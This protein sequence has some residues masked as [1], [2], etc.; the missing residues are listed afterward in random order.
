M[1][2]SDINK[3]SE[4]HI[5][6]EAKREI[7]RDLMEGVERLR[8]KPA[9]YLPKNATE[10][11]VTVDGNV[12][13]PWANRVRMSRL[14]NMFREAVEDAS[15]RAFAKPAK[16]SANMPEKLVE[17]LLDVDGQGS[18][19]QVFGKEVAET[20][21]SE[22]NDF[23]LVDFP[24]RPPGEVLTEEQEA[25][26]RLA[27]FWRRYS[28]ANVIDWKFGTR[29][30]EVRL[31]WVKLREWTDGKLQV[32]K[33]IAGAEGAEDES[34][35][36]RFEVW[37]P[38][39]EGEYSGEWV[40]ERA[41]SMNPQVDIPLVEFPSDLAAPFCARPPYLD[42]AHLTIA[43]YRKLSDL[44]NAQHAVGYPLL[45]WAGAPQPQLDNNG[46][47]VPLSS[48][49]L[50]LS[51]DPAAHAEFIE[52]QGHAWASLRVEL[53]RMEAEGKAM[54]AAPMSQ[55]VTVQL[56][57]TD[58][59][60][61]AAGRTTKLQSWVLG[62][63]DSFSMCLCYTAVFLGIVKPDA[64]KGWGAIEL[65]GQFLP[66]GSKVEAAR[67]AHERNI[68]GKLSDESTHEAM[69]RAEVLPE[70]LDFKAERARI[71][72]EGLTEPTDEDRNAPDMTGNEEQDAA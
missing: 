53:D 1:P 59:A 32:R 46:K 47:P 63:Q 71:D 37:K 41:G 67:L 36:A 57:A 39:K 72:A 28:P 14:T 19:F 2:S 68:A 44:D 27:P 13:D 16:P 35:F 34:A 62:W 55:E 43:H 7:P 17:F 60:I 21:V 20:S 6:L 10:K 30:R 49:R 26:L 56:T 22:G 65:N 24:S 45:H 5:A 31:E 18:N 70:T 4:K 38:V 69:V 40:I 64:D 29:G 61:R 12:I 3:P 25:A 33:L 42:L 9:T 52:P 50:L 15:G 66:L 11:V 51:N 54:S 48:E 23:V 8:E 58:A